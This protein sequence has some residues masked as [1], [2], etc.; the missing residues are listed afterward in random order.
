MT[1]QL[2]PARVSRLPSALVR[3]S[4][5]TNF[6]TPYVPRFGPTWS[7]EIHRRR[8]RRTTHSLSRLELAKLVAPNG[9]I[10]PPT[11]VCVCVQKPVRPSDR[12]LTSAVST[13]PASHL[14]P[15]TTTKTLDWSQPHGTR[16]ANENIP[17][18]FDKKK[19]SHKCTVSLAP[20]NGHR[21]P[22]SAQSV[23]QSVSQIFRPSIAPS[24]RHF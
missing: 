4:S 19:S 5:S 15:A 20:T 18:P 11:G 2:P 23:S 12:K 17:L 13:P 6:G 9:C 16:Y 24:V 14:F 21:P 8:R 1:L 7:F 3:N 10:P 22:S